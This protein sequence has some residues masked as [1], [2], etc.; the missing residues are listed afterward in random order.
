M[1]LN[2]KMTENVQSL[3]QIRLKPVIDSGIYQLFEVLIKNVD[4]NQTKAKFVTLC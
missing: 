1:K 2:T 3:G 4:A